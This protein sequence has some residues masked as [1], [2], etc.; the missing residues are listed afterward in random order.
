MYALKEDLENYVVQVINE[1]LPFEVESDASEVESDASEVSFAA[2]LSQAAH[3]IA[4]FSRDFQ[5]PKKFYASFEKEAQTIIGA[6]H[7]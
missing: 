2:V 4:F 6:D 7:H 3:P 5:G 1:F